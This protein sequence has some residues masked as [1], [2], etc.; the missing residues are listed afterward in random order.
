M[1]PVQFCNAVPDR[2][3]LRYTQQGKIHQ[4]IHW[5]KNPSGKVLYNPDLL[6]QLILYGGDVNHPDRQKVVEKY[7]NNRPENQAE[8]PGNTA[9]VLDKLVKDVRN[10]KGF[11]FLGLVLCQGGVKVAT[12]HVEFNL[13]GFHRGGFTVGDRIRQTDVQPKSFSLP[14]PN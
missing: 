6:G 1:K 5:G 3:L 13:A 14:R 8:K 7:L 4:G 9:L 12:S 2:T 10:R 11:L